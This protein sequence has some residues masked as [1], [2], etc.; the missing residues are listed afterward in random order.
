MGLIN[1]DAIARIFEF[2]DGDFLRLIVS[3]LVF[4]M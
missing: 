1:E 2:E 4:L 3:G